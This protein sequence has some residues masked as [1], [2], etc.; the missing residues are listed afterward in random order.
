MVTSLVSA[1]AKL[2]QHS[3][4]LLGEVTHA[5]NHYSRS[6]IVDGGATVTRIMRDSTAERPS[7]FRKAEP[8]KQA[9][10][11]DDACVATAIEATA[12]GT[13]IAVPSCKPAR[14]RPIPA[15]TSRMRKRS[16]AAL[17]HQQQEDAAGETRVA[18]WIH[19]VELRPADGPSAA[20]RIASLRARLRDKSC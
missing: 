15:N 2:V 5:A 14:M 1:A 16:A 10:L 12:S 8:K 11:L 7:K 18:E 9:S 19:R 3:A 17:A 20:D 4:A 13:A 6:E